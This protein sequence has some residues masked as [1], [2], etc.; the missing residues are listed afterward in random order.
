MKRLSRKLRQLAQEKIVRPILKEIE[1]GISEEQLARSV[2]IG[3]TGGVFPVPGLTLLC[4]FFLQYI[5]S[6]SFIVC[7]AINVLVTPAHFLSLK[8]FYGYGM[9][10][11]LPQRYLVSSEELLKVQKAIIYSFTTFFVYILGLYV[12]WLIFACGLINILCCIKAN[13]PLIDET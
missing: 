3:I 10:Y 7:Q 12:H 11:V 4:S 5:F 6:A 9:M 8:L 2:A 1:T 13:I